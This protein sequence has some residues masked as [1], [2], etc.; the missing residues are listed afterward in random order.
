MKVISL[1]HFNHFLNSVFSGLSD[2]LVGAL[3][4]VGALIFVGVACAWLW[5][6]WRRERRVAQR[7]ALDDREAQDGVGEEA[8][9]AVLGPTGNTGE[10]RV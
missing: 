3:V 8:E 1:G 9:L 5:R 6:Q 7:L 4:L 2:E 10:S